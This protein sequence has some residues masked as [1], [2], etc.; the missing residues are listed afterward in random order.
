LSEILSIFIGATDEG[1][2][3]YFHSF[4]LRLPGCNLGTGRERTF[5]DRSRG[6]NAGIILMNG[7]FLAQIQH[8]EGRATAKEISYQELKDEY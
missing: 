4:Y 1:Y 7:V 6:S 3:S 5:R 2:L 8:P